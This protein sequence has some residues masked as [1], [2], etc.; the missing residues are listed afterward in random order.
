MYTIMCLFAPY[1]FPHVTTIDSQATVL[2][3]SLPHE[4]VHFRL[5][6]A[7]QA[8]HCPLA[9]RF[10]STPPILCW[11]VPRMQRAADHPSRMRFNAQLPTPSP[12]T[13]TTILVP[14]SLGPRSPCHCDTICDRFATGAA[15]CDHQTR[16]LRY[17]RSPD[18]MF[19]VSAFARLVFLGSSD[20]HTRLLR[21][22]YR[23]TRLLRSPRSPNSSFPR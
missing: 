19:E 7:V 18:S 6:L 9:G 11:G 2:R 3:R 1:Q 20:R 22:R 8:I 12:P 4:L 5:M 15:R 13:P 17:P 14:R 16:F 23:Q 10:F 21:S